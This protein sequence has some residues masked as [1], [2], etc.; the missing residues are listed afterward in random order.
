MDVRRLVC[1]VVLLLLKITYSHV[2]AEQS[3]L[4]SE[5]WTLENMPFLS[6]IFAKSKYLPNGLCKEDAQKFLYDLRNGTVWATQSKFV[7]FK[8]FLLL[9]RNKVMSDAI[10]LNYVN[11]LLFSFICVILQICFN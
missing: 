3:Q 4:I 1:Y 7:R 5:Q 10:L 2:L 6:I 11:N 8:I 9:C